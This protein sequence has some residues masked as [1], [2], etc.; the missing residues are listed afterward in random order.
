VTRKIDWGRVRGARQ[1]LDKL[2]LEHPELLGPPSTENRRGWEHD[3]EEIMGRG[4]ESA[5]GGE[6]MQVAFRLPAKL[7]ARLD[8]HVERMRRLSPGVAFTRA[9]AVRSLLTVALTTAEE[10]EAVAKRKR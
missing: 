5:L 4:T 7:V 3:L 2:A 8:Q 6:T 10:A 1:Q 9:D